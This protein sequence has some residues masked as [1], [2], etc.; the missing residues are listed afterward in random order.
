MTRQLMRSA[1]VTALGMILLSGTAR[2]QDVGAASVRAKNNVAPLLVVD[3]II[4][5]DS[6]RMKERL[7]IEPR[8]ILGVD[9]VRGTAARDLY[10]AAGADGVII[11][12]T[13]IMEDATQVTDDQRRWL[14]VLQQIS[15]SRPS[16]V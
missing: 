12:R 15:A 9:I 16:D 6:R 11:V 14:A 5:G 10:G 3:G 2:G 4:I 13:K 1:T 7:R 8:E